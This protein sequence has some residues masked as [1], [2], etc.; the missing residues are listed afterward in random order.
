MKSLA[1]AAKSTNRIFFACNFQ[2][3]IESEET[4]YCRTLIVPMSFA[5]ETNQLKT[6]FKVYSQ[7]LS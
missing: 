6:V 1:A 7:Y 4:C 3:F 5:F 2:E